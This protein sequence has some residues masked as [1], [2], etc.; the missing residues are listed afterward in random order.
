MLNVAA[1]PGFLVKLTGCVV[2]EGANAINNS[3]ASKGN[4]LSGGNQKAL[5]NYQTGAASADYETWLADQ[6]KA[7]QAN[8][9]QPMQ[10]LSGIAG[11]GE[12]ATAAT[13]QLG[14]TL[15]G[16]TSSNYMRAGE[17]IATNYYNQVG[18]MN[19]WASSYSNSAGSFG[20]GMG[21]LFG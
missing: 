2:I 7:Q 20:A 18:N 15:A 3:A 8:Y 13:N 19:N 5:S 10:A 12:Q 14:T 9:W 6:Y 16:E 4:L 1:S 21:G 11:Q 17:D